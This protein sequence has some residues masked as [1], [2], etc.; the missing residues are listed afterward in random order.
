MQHYYKQ[1][2]ENL[3]LYGPTNFSEFLSHAATIA[4]DA[5]VG[6]ENQE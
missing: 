5:H 1:A 2:V 6:Q 3:T 4:R